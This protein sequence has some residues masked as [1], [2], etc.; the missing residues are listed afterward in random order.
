M[1]DRLATVNTVAREPRADRAAIGAT[2]KGR[3]TSVS[4]ALDPIDSLG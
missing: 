3:A 1:V 2:E 4:P